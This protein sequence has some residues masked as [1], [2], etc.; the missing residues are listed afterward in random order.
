M[1]NILR[2]IGTLAPLFVLILASPVLAHQ[3]RIT[4][5]VITNVVDPEVSKAYYAQLSNEPQMY[6]IH[7]TGSFNLYVNILIPDIQWSPKDVQAT[8]FKDGDFAHPIAT[9]GGSKAQWEYFFEPFGYDA[10]WQWPEYRSRAG[11]WVYQI[12]VSS[13]FNTSKY[14]LAVGEIERF[15]FDETINALALIP[16][17]KRDFFDES[18]MNFIFS[19]FGWWIIAILFIC[20][21]VFGTLLR[22]FLRKILHQT[23]LVKDKNIGDFDRW[24]RFILSMLLLLIAISTSWNLWLIFASGFCFFEAVFGWCPIYMI[25]GKNSCKTST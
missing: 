24:M 19:P 3:P 18:P 16:K 21:F 2:K 5:N 4:E 12:Q 1:K 10:Y 7:A 23:I 25:F 15:D 17:L 8:I 20:A 9:L 14:A 13:P 6:V 22:L 11:S